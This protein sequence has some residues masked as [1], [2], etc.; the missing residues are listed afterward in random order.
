MTRDVD[1]AISLDQDNLIRLWRALEGTN[2]R[3]RGQMN[4]VRRFTEEDARR[5]DWKNVYLRTDLGPLDCLGS[6]KAVGDYEACLARSTDWDFEGYAVRIL[7]RTALIEAKL[8]VGR[9][10][11]IQAVNQLKVLEG[12]EDDSE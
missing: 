11:D 3:Y 1:V 6:V 7:D 5:D 2:P 12:I 9:P 4:P 10:R 8:A